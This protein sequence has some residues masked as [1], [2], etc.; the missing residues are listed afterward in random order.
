MIRIGEN[1]VID[2]DENCFTV[3][4]LGIIQNENSKNCG[5]EKETV[6]G[7]YSTLEGALKGLEKHLQRKTIRIKDYTLKEAIEA[8][9]AL[10]EDYF[11]E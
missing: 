8:L 7:Y 9:K 6:Y 11:K 1:Y 2:S 3:K 5:K 10:H 4:E